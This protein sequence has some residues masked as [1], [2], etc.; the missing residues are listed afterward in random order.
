MEFNSLKVNQKSDTDRL[1][2]GQSTKLQVFDTPVS[3]PFDFIL[4]C[5]LKQIIGQT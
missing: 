3:Y 5:N 2:F 1:P 4:T